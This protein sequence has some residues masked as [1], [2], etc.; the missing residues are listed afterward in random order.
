[1][2]NVNFHKEQYNTQSL[3]TI[4]YRRTSFTLR[5]NPDNRVK[6]DHSE[7]LLD[8]FTFFSRKTP[9]YTQFEWENESTIIKCT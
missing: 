1:M 9:S 7:D 8:S 5:K 3:Y 6:K 4:I 2:K